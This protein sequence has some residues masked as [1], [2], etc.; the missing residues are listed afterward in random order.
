MEESIQ[1]NQNNQNE[2]LKENNMLDNNLSDNK[3]DTQIEP[4]TKGNYVY[5]SLCS[6]S[7]NISCCIS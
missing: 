4:I 3:I 6:C 1:N 7:F 2:K 5:V